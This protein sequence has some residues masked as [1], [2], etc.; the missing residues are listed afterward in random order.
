MK[1]TILITAGAKRL[2]KFISEAMLEENWSIALHY[3][4]SKILAE[5]TAHD[6]IKRGGEVSLYYADFFNIE[7][8]EKLIERLSDE[9]HN[10]TGL[11]NNAGL[12]NYDCGKDYNLQSLNDHMAVNFSVPAILIKGLYKKLKKEKIKNTNIAINMIDA[13]IFGLNPDYYSYTLSKFSMFGL[14]KI[15]ALSYAPI[16]RVNGIAPG[17][18]LPVKNQNID[19]FKKAHKKNLLGKSST[20][21]E[22]ILALKFLINSPSIT[23]HVSILDG[24]AHL[25]PPR[26][27]VSI[28]K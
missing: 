11:I 17:I 9:K 5:E 13:K 23:G 21:E 18:T 3:N 14:T 2:G 8:V 12:F 10:W 24:G 15:A 1:K 28:E 26:R 25:S 22:I 4:T 6:L 7:T 27:D 20:V 19:K 16:L